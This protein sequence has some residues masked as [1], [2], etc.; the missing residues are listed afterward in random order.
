MLAEAQKPSATYQTRPSR[1]TSGTLLDALTFDYLSFKLNET[2]TTMC[3]WKSVTESTIN[4]V[5]HFSSPS[6]DLILGAVGPKG[7]AHR[8]R[9][10]LYPWKN[11]RE[12]FGESFAFSS[13]P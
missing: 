5:F 13:V 4:I 9:Q 10:R 2:N 11:K 7:C 3:S 12:A 6:F 1:T 8:S